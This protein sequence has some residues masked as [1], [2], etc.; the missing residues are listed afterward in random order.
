[1]TE[2]PRFLVSW[3]NGNSFNC[4][5]FIQKLIINIVYLSLLAVMD[6]GVYLRVGDY[7]TLKN[8]KIGCDGYLAADGILQTDVVVRDIPS[9][10]EDSLYCVHL[11]RQYAACTELNDF[12]ESSERVKSKAEVSEAEEKRT[13]KYLSALIVSFYERKYS[14]ADIFNGF[15]YV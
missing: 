2:G 4:L 1:M 14:I 8:V 3:R 15:V 9:L 6:E 11:Q 12:L 13:K 7:I 5:I 10:F